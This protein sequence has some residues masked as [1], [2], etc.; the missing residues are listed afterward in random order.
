M[1]IALIGDLQFEPEEEERLS[2]R[3]EQVKE[4]EP[5]LAVFLGDMGCNARLGSREG[6]Q[7]AKKLLD[8]L[9]RPVIALLGNHDVEYRPESGER[10]APLQWYDETF[11]GRPWRAVE[12][13][14][15]LLLCLSVEPQPRES[16]LTRHSLYVSEEQFAWAR[17]QLEKHPEKPTILF[18]HAPMAG[19]GIRC[20][21]PIHSAATDAY[22]DHSYQALRW[23]KLARENP[24]IR[25][26]CS[27]HFHMGHDYPAALTWAEDT[28]HI[29]CGVASSA[30]RDGCR[31]T[32]FL[33]LGEGKLIVST[34][35]HD[36]E[37]GLRRDATLNLRG[38]RQ[39]PAEAFQ[40]DENEIAVGVDEA[41]RVFALPERGKLYLATKEGKLWEYDRELG[42][43]EG[44]LRLHA[45][46]E[47]LAFAQE[48]LYWQEESGE[49]F[50]VSL[51]D[52]ARFERLSEY[53]TQRARREETIPS[54]CL[55]TL[56][57][58]QRSRREGTCV[59][60]EMENW[61]A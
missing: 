19:S 3:M 1:K 30:A 9:E 40:R 2:A 52:R 25:A 47:R 61:D 7:S 4:Q 17:E 29:S 27:A 38:K 39:K 15:A 34:L 10:P 5:D 24:Q 21:P 23:K 46:V 22:L 12:T 37:G 58:S 42:E 33:E 51:A 50:S 49:A 43:L 53:P 44:A 20:C 6:A 48:R 60:V 57:F 59:K 56:A 36:Q 35:T 14:E 8:R 18:T 28:L 55:P 26:W 45:S 54:A 11:G 31:Q 16:W 32:R 41:V 13:E